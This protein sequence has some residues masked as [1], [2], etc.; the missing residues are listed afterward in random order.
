MARRMVWR[1]HSGMRPHVAGF[2]LVVGVSMASPCL[3]QTLP[4]GFQDSAVITGLT[5]PMA[6]RFAPDGRI[7]VAEKSGLIKVF[8]SLQDPAPVVFAI[9]P[10]GLQPNRQASSANA[11]ADLIAR[12]RLVVLPP[13][14]GPSGSSGEN[15]GGLT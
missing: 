11:F 3:S 6:V 4:S 2:A 14:S 12:S 1:Y 13:P 7:F 9:V 5:L 8:D 15:A 10:V